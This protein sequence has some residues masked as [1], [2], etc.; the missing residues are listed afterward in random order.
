MYRLCLPTIN[1]YE[2]IV[3]DIKY[4]TSI[5][6]IK[7]STEKKSIS[8]RKVTNLLKITNFVVKRLRNI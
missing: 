7:E 6:K 4:K 1:F 2:F 8:S 5:Y 3:I